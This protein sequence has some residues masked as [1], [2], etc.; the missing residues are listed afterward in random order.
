VRL[1]CDPP[2]AE[3]RDRPHSSGGSPPALAP[4]GRSATLMSRLLGVV[5]LGDCLK[6]F[7]LR[8]LSGAVSTVLGGLVATTSTAC[9]CRQHD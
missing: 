8:G 9:G 6:S 5:P 4:L 1:R 2:L 7:P 3:N